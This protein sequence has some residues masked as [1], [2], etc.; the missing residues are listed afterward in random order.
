MGPGADLPFSAKG[1]KAFTLGC[2][3]SAVRK[4]QNNRLARPPRPLVAPQRATSAAGPSPQSQGIKTSSYQIPKI[5]KTAAKIETI[6]QPRAAPQPAPQ[7]AQAAAAALAPLP[8]QNMQPPG[9]VSRLGR[10][11]GGD[12]AHPGHHGHTPSGRATGRAPQQQQANTAAGGSTKRGRS[13]SSNCDEPGV[14][15]GTT[16]K[17]PKPQYGFGTKKELQERQNLASSI[18]S[19]PE[20]RVVSAP[21]TAPLERRVETCPPRGKLM[22]L[23]HV[24]LEGGGFAGYNGAD[25]Q[26]AMQGAPFA[27]DHL[28]RSVHGRKSACVQCPPKERPC[29]EVWKYIRFTTGYE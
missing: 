13:T 5:P 11:A 10:A 21:P 20:A 18:K 14:Q 4:S 24:P 12:V 16:S 27:S 8:R 15:R 9:S 25:G 26:A 2:E 19:P 7:P 29:M 6:S 3:E 17:K 1:H 23:L 22:E 28:Q